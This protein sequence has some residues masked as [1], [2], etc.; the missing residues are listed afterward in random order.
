MLFAGGQ[1]RWRGQI[2]EMTPERAER[3]L[4]ADKRM[5]RHTITV[6]EDTGL[7]INTASRDELIALPGV[8][9]G[10]ADQIMALRPFERLEDVTAVSGIGLATVKR[11]QGVRA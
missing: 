4:Q 7:S 10:R 9:E 1:P 6:L 5:G 11:W 8:G 3:L 2:V